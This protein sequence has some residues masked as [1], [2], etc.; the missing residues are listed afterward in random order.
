MG[1]CGII[2][3]MEKKA[4]ILA[5]D[6]E[7]DIREVLRLLLEADGYAV[8]EASSGDEALRKLT[9]DVSLVVLDVV[10]PGESGYEVCERLRERSNVPV[11]FLTAKS[12]EQDKVRGL[13]C[14]GDDYLTKPFSAAELGARVAALL[15]R[16]QVYQGSADV[17]SGRF[18]R[19][20]VCIDFASGTVARNEKQVLLTDL[21]YRLLAY[22]A[23][24]AGETIDAQR[25]YEAVWGET[26]LLSSASTIMVH[27]RNLR[28]KLEDDPQ[29]PALIKTVWGKGYRID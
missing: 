18:V 7:A 26:Y 13:Q 1:T 20:S 19:Q 6:D 22:L 14:G 10:M 17:Q 15:R 4:V 24:H 16:Y 25:L 9:E 29:Q 2:R 5:V 11:L 12:Q 28:K 3:H 21:E 27:I 23:K 8:C